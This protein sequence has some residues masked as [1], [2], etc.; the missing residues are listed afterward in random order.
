MQVLL[1]ISSKINVIVKQDTFCTFTFNSPQ[2]YK[3]SWEMK[4]QGHSDEIQYLNSLSFLM[5]LTKETA[6]C[7]FVLLSLCPSLDT[8][9]NQANL[10]TENDIMKNRGLV[11][12]VFSFS[13]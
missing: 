3:A 4:F 13:P 8:V 6:D 9:C 10:F 1:C 2:K 11:I 12:N 5:L 7:H